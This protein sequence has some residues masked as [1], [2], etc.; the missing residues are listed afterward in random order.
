MARYIVTPENNVES[1]IGGTPRPQI[2]VSGALTGPRGFTGSTGLTGAPGA[3]G[4][5]GPQG[6]QGVQGPTGP[7]GPQG[8]A[9]ISRYVDVTEHGALGTGIGD[10]SPGF[11]AAIAVALGSNQPLY[12]PPG[13]YPFSTTVE[14]TESLFIIGDGESSTIRAGIGLND[15]MFTVNPINEDVRILMS[16]LKFDGNVSAQ[17]SGG[18]I[19]VNGAVEGQ[20]T[21]LHFLNC[22]DWGLVLAGFATMAFGHHNRV[23][24][25]LFDSNFAN[26]GLGGGIKMTSSDENLIIGSN[27]QYLGGSGTANPAMIL[28][29]AGLQ[30]IQNCVFVGSLGGNTNVRGVQL[31][32]GNRSYVG[33]CTFDGVGGDNIFV[34]GQMHQLVGNRFTFP[35]DQG[36]GYH[37]GIHLEVG[38]TENTIVA[39]QFDA[40][41]AGANG[42]RSYIRESDGDPGNNTIVGCVFNEVGVLN[43]GPLE[44]R[45]TPEPPTL[46]A[47]CIP[48]ALNTAVS[49]STNLTTTAAPTTVAINSDTGTD[50]AIAAADGTNAGL[51][52][53]AEKTKLTG[54]ATGATANDTDANLRARASHTGTQL[55]GTIS[56]FAEAVSD[57]LGTMVTGNTES[58]IT[59]AYDDT[60]NT[61]D[62]TVTDSP[63]LG[64]QNSAF[65][66]ARANHTGSQLASTISDFAESVDDRVSALL[67]AGT[68]VTL[69]YNDGA[70]TLTVAATG[71]GGTGD[72]VG[73]AASTDNAFARFDGTTGKLLQNSTGATLSD[74]G[75]AALA[76]LTVDTDVLVVDA[77]NNRVGVNTATPAEA[78]HF[79]GNLRFDDAATPVKNMRIRTTGGDID[80]EGA[81]KSI[82]VSVWSTVNFTGTQR[83][84]LVLESGSDNTQAIGN[85]Q[86]RPAP[87]GASHHIIS[88]LAG[89]V[90]TFNEDAQDTDFRVEGASLTHAF[91][92]D[93]SAATENIALVAAAAPNWQAMDRGL[94]IGDATTVPTGNPTAGG[95]LYVEAGALKYRGS[96]GTITTVGAA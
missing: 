40:A 77:T 59:V 33:G 48:R 36:I 18:G 41:D 34:K 69:T 80:F 67:V 49:G 87:F 57:Q 13:V 46:V 85:W 14:I 64:G 86:F 79:I 15:Y 68:N 51:F 9:G 20:Y 90:A 74:T 53:P 27:F 31:D 43:V 73:P 24:N 76:G 5:V 72:V 81:G 89:G 22:C 47:D 56:D 3:Q 66:I 23:L 16:N 75:V 7:V 42:T 10:D 54:I 8:P 2:I 58:G 50:A 63:L 29:Q 44:L 26:P 88:G 61:L 25:C 91:F 45:T 60:D 78:F 35:G 83:N 32:S 21:G 11:R 82:F 96:G 92:L 93:A 95:F 1:L 84:K 70:N 71:G 30:I 52:L 17:T 37:S 12:V 28:D 94:F 38:A 65:H 6:T 62:F 19:L 4:T 55:S 39:C